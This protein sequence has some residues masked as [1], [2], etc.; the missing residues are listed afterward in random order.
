MLFLSSP[1]TSL[2]NLIPVLEQFK[3]ISNLKI[4]YSK[5]FALNILLSPKLVQLCQ[6]NF[7][8]CWKTDAITYLGIQL[9]G[10]LKDLYEKNF[11]SELKNIQ[12][13]LHK[14]EAPTVFWFGRASILKMTVLPRILHK[15]Q[16]IPIHLPPSFFAEEDVQ[17]LSLGNQGSSNWVSEAGPTK[18]WGWHRFAGS[19]EVLLGCPPS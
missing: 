7:P 13:D 6:S 16:T 10:R 4:N 2:P 5:S 12:Q 19:P 14:W 15:M 17:G 8:F 18:I 3:T 1:L 11:L 9:P